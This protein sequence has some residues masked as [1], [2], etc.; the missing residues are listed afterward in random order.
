M[1][2]LPTPAA[3]P[4]CKSLQTCDCCLCS[5]WVYSRTYSPSYF[6]VDLLRSASRNPLKSDLICGLLHLIFCPPFRQHSWFHMFIQ[7]FTP[8]TRCQM[9]QDYLVPMEL[10]CLRP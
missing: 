9:K 6:L 3:P 10:S 4:P 5:A 2:W 1:F 8:S 7:D